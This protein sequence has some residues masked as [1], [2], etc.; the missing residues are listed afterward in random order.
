MSVFRDC[1]LRCG[2][3]LNVHIIF[4]ELA[5]WNPELRA[6]DSTELTLKG[7]RPVPADEGSRGYL[8]VVG[9]DD[10]AWVTAHGSIRQVVFAGPAALADEA[11]P[12]WRGIALPEADDSLSVIARVQEVFDSYQEWEDRMLLILARRGSLRDVLRVGAER[13]RNPIALFDHAIVNVAQG[14]AVPEI[15]H[16][17]I[18]NEVLEDGYSHI[19]HLSSEERHKVDKRLNDPNGGPFI[20]EVAAY[21]NEKELVASLWR[22]DEFVG[23]L[24]S[25][26]IVAPFTLGQVSIVRALR[27]VLEVELEAGASPNGLS[28]GFGTLVLRLLARD[29]LPKDYVRRRLDDLGLSSSRFE[30]AFLLPLEGEA[31]SPPLLP[32]MAVALARMTKAAYAGEYAGGIVALYPFGGP[33]SPAEDDDA[34]EDI[35]GRLAPCLEELGLGCG[36]SMPY[37]DIFQTRRAF[38][39]ASLAAR[40][41]HDAPVANR[42]DH[43]FSDVVMEALS[44]VFPPDRFIDSWLA[45][46]LEEGEKGED[47]LRTL[48]TYITSD[49]NVSEASRRLYL[50]RNTVM[51]RLEQLSKL[52]GRNLEEL[53][54]DEELYLMM[55]C[56]LLE[57]TGEGDNSS[58]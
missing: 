21:P 41:R 24:G 7:V 16:P 27:D 39:Q 6:S 31:Q 51:Y 37:A 2:M 15:T 13:L 56:L 49:R 20:Q 35:V 54:F 45:D 40:A 3:K 57:K 26:D 14:G 19:E 4:D 36:L 55:S 9:R 33:A 58:R 44:A 29:D 47:L 48:R 43:V 10:L 11:Y 52:L 18:W 12:D 46:C 30:L 25:V 34:V 8:Y 5:D 38:D 22:R 42:F 32:S 50:H 23:A 28:E 17:S 53:T 1:Y